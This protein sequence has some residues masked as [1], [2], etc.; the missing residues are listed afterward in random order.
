MKFREIEVSFV[1]SRFL[2]VVICPESSNFYTPIYFAAPL[3][4]FL[5]KHW[6]FSLNPTISH[7]KL[8]S[9]QTPRVLGSRGSPLPPHRRAS[10]DAKSIVGIAKTVGIV[11]WNNRRPIGRRGRVREQTFLIPDIDCSLPSGNPRASTKSGV[12]WGTVR[13][14]EEGCS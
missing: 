3:Y 1:T 5:L 2:I 4:P 7:T 10:R 11:S 9:K 14:R 8:P 13:G 12:G 6:Y